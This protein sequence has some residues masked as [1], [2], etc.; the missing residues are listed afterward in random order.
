MKLQSG[1]GVG[2]GG[3]PSQP[4]AGYSGELLIDVLCL[5]ELVDSGFNIDCYN[6]D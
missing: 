3:C 4:R 5:L 6:K 1:S 2:W